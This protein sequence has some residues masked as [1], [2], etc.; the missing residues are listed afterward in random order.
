MSERAR[1]REQFN[2]KPA[3]GKKLLLSARKL[4]GQV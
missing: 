2:Q 3:S 4:L 1:K